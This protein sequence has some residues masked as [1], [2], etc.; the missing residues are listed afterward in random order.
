[1]RQIDFC[2]NLFKEYYEKR[3]IIRSKAVGFISHWRVPKAFELMNCPFC[4]KFKASHID[5]IDNPN[6][7]HTKPK[8]TKKDKYCCSRFAEFVKEGEFYYAYEDCKDI[9]ETAWVISGVCHMYY[10]PFCGKYIKGRGFGVVP[11]S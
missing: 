6:K 10:C 2:C 9:D 4:G 7:S 1:M 3:K 11:K 8:V 5:S